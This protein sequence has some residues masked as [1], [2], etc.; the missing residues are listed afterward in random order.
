VVHADPVQF[1][2]R[3]AWCDGLAFEVGVVDAGVGEFVG[4]DGF[5]DGASTQIAM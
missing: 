4:D 2:E 5:D 1:C 3:P